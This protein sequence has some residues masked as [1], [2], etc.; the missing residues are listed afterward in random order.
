MLSEGNF[1]ACCCCFFK[2]TDIRLLFINQP[3]HANKRLGVRE[4]ERENEF[5]CESKRN[6]KN[7]EQSRKPQC[8]AADFLCADT[9]IAEQW[10]SAHQC[11]AY[12]SYAFSVHSHL[13]AT[14]CAITALVFASFLRLS[15]EIE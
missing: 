12:K 4:R 13:L 8:I 15:R 1:L 6:G 10:H 3:L 7:R 14:N 2:R 9:Q 5:D 11:N